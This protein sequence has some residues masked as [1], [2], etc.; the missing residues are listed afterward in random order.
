MR[1]SGVV[2]SDFVAL[3]VTLS[4][5]CGRSACTCDCKQK[6]CEEHCSRS[7]VVCLM[8]FI[9]ADEGAINDR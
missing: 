2:L 5:A 8:P 6:Q 4:T 7:C 1:F 3:L 9:H